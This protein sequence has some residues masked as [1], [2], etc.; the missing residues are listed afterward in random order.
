MMHGFNIRVGM[1]FLIAPV[2]FGILALIVAVI[3]GNASEGF[4]ALRLSA[5]LGYPVALLTGLPAYLWMAQR[6]WVG[7]PAYLGLAVVYAVV[8]SVWLFLR[9]ALMRPESLNLNALALQ[10]GA[11]LI[12]C[13]ITL[14][15]F[16]L[17]ARPDKRG[18]E[19]PSAG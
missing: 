10:S 9:P 2:A 1:A 16:W 14:V 13:V 7:L 8:L 5:L 6:R 12:G 18:G 11:V 17:I 3:S 15:I 4:W 19:R